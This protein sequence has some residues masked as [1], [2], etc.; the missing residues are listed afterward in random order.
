[1]CVFADCSAD[2]PALVVKASGLAAG[3]GV[4]VCSNKQEACSAVSQILDQHT[5]GAA[6]NTVVVEELLT[7]H[8]VS[9]CS[10][11]ACSEGDGIPI[12]YLPIDL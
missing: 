8:E 10:S 5:F 9:V 2:F 3:K 12:R 4:L 11:F 1:M 6:G 7:G